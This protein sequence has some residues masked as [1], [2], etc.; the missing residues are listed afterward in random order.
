MTTEAA[1]VEFIPPEIARGESVPDRKNALAY[2]NYVKQNKA[3]AAMYKESANTDRNVLSA[4]YLDF[5]T[6]PKILG[7]VVESFLKDRRKPIMVAASDDFG[8]K[9]VNIKIY[10]S[11]NNLLDSGQGRQF[12]QNSK[13]YYFPAISAEEHHE[14][15]V[16][17]RA[18][19]HPG[20]QISFRR[21]VNM[22]EFKSDN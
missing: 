8:V 16:E 11:A 10:D 6:P 15:I 14:L 7:I 13:W 9:N 4:A 21:K 19:D 1:I 22:K 3:A 17:A 5:I 18:F 20:N 2:V 12:L